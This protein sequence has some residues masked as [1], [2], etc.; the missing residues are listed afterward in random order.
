MTY[1]P[2]YE[3]LLRANSIVTDQGKVYVSAVKSNCRHYLT[4]LQETHNSKELNTLV[5]RGREVKALYEMIKPFV[6]AYEEA[7]KE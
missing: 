6:E 5:L 1:N 4:L 2:D 7:T 3:Q